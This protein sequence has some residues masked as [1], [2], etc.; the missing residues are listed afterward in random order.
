MLVTVLYVL[1]IHTRT[2]HP[3]L[4]CDSFI[5]RE[6]IYA[7]R[8]ECVCCFQSKIHIYIL[9]GFISHV[10]FEPKIT[11]S[12]MFTRTI[13]SYVLTYVP[14]LPQTYT[15]NSVDPHMELC[16]GGGAF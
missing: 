16:G 2:T 8:L 3:T 9:G 7:S 14:T 5:Y 15:V 12:T 11:P 6:R 13:L 1:C 4:A 10:V